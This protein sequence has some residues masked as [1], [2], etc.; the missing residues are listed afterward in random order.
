MSTTVTHTIT[1]TAEQQ[2]VLESL[3][4]PHLHMRSFIPESDGS[5]SAVNIID[6][7]A[8][9]SYEIN[10]DGTYTVEELED[11]GC[12]WNPLGE[13]EEDNEDED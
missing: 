11:F 7:I 1:I 6:D 10:P 8:V 5:I 4:S 9:Q 13:G 3:S 12:G 2:A